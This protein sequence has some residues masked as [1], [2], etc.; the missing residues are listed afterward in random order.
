MT[1][2]LERPAASSGKSRKQRGP[3]GAT[4]VPR[5]PQVN[6]LPPEVHAKRTLSRVKRWLAAVLVL[7]VLLAAGLVALAVLSQQAAEDELSLQQSETERLLAEQQRYAEV[8]L[9][10]DQ[11]ESIRTARE[12]AMG[13]EVMWQDYIAAIAATAPEGVSIESANVTAPSPMEPAPIAAD[14]LVGDAVAGIT[15][16]ANSRTVPDTAAW[17]DG[18][19]SV[20]GLAD[21]WFSS[22]SVTEVDGVVFYSVSG[23]VQ[24]HA[25]ARSGRFTTTEGDE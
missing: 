23:T 16:S 2:T 8:P 24:V 9:V 1:A 3:N 21:A 12:L 19:N 15:F 6:L 22:A 17:I 5:L 10:L 20:P 14:P 7:A 25:D 4:V 11:L 18:L 13:T